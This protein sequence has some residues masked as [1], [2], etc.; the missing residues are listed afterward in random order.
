M[1]LLDTHVWI[2]WLSDAEQL[3]KKAIEAINNAVQSNAIY[4]SSI[5][6]WEVVTL[7]KK[8]RLQFTIDVS[9]WIKHA[10]SLPFLNFIPVNNNIAM[11]SVY[12][13]GELHNDPADRI[14]I[15]TAITMG[16]SLVTK[17][18]KIHI[19]KHIDTIW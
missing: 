17:D 14:I 15:A 13:K 1:I 12:L 3:S 11:K 19:Y 9:D 2:W 4:V 10:E 16:A 7:V 8:S 5:S 18:E 6:V